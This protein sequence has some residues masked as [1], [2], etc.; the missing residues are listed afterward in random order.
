MT[1]P[2]KEIL[3]RYFRGAC[4][5][6]EQELVEL[7]LSMDT[8]KDYI[9]ACIAEAWDQLPAREDTSPDGPGL[10][11]FMR[12]FEQR[13]KTVIQ[14]PPDHGAVHGSRFRPA[15]WMKVAAAVLLLAGGIALLTYKTNVHTPAAQLAQQEAILPGSEK[16]VL[17]LADG[18]TVSLSEAKR[19]EIALQEGLAVEKTADG[20]IV[21]RATG[22]A[23]IKPG[24]FNKVATPK[25]GQYRITL[26]DGSVA[27]L[28]AASSL[29]YPVHFG[30]KERRVKMTGEVYFEI[31]KAT[32]S[33]NKRIPFFVQT[34]KQE[35]EVLGTVF[36]VNAYADEAHQL[37]TL[38]EG[39]VRLK[40][41]IDNSYTV[42]KP[43]ER[44]AVGTSVMVSPANIKQ[45]LAWVNGNFVFQRE[46]LGS[47][48]R[49]I[50]RWYDLEVACPPEL[51]NITFT[52]KVSRSQ[53]LS[54]VV[55][56]IAATGKI[57]VQ[58]KE[59]RIIVT[60]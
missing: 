40:S 29:S 54:A 23:A 2:P 49:K 42:L 20:E 31:A 46:A 9:E 16:A 3:L 50:S 39:S 21:Y 22:T 55:A 35:I 27:M 59:R 15:V 17:T 38:V 12:E 58:L 10:E 43:G 34:E 60:K 28:N 7:Y 13:K 8:D 47:I 52:G 53:P 18:S 1:R 5:P 19:G 41:E 6:H 32:G 25:G 24:A 44:A 51:A 36:N 56:M 4:Q 33:N 26:P 48:L 37:T 30:E 45:E 57:N 11:K 14:L